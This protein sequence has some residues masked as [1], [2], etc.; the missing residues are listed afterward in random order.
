MDNSKNTHL[1]ENVNTNDDKGEKPRSNKEIL[2]EARL[3]RPPSCSL[4]I[5]ENFYKDPLQ[6]REFILQQDFF[7]GRGSYPGRRSRSYANSHLR[8]IIQS[9]IEPFAGKI[10]DF[11]NADDGVKQG[12]Y[13]Q[14]GAFEITTSRDFD[15]I[16]N[17]SDSVTYNWAGVVYLN[18][19]APL[20]AGANFYEFYDGCMSEQDSIIIN[21][22][23]EPKR[24]RFDRTK[25][26]IVD[27]VSNM[28]N[29][30][31]LFNSN[32]YHAA[33]YYFGD[34]KENGRLFQIFFFSTER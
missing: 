1:I 16:H 10:I 21:N 18:P 8:E 13:I 33:N 19:D 31:I 26:R 30:L 22:V 5:I 17:D 2:F 20:N 32:R 7:V 12:L 9:Y 15:W 29:R 23:D 4:V 28:F 3:K 24:W 14:N 27:Q 11:P 6:V 34:S 25:W